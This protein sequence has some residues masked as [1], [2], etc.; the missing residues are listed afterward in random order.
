MSHKEKLLDFTSQ[1]DTDG[2][3]VEAVDRVLVVIPVEGIIATENCSG[4]TTL[5]LKKK[6]KDSKIHRIMDSYHINS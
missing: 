6:K 4:L 3:D 1:K 5:I 2:E